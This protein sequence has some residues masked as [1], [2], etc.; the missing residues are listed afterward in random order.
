MTILF[1]VFIYG[2]TTTKTPVDYVN[3]YI[4]NISHLLVPTFPT[5]HLPNSM[6][7][8]YPEREN[9]TSNRISGLP[10]I[11][12]SHRGA[13]AF[14]L[15][16]FDGELENVGG[17]LN[18]GYDNEIIKPYYYQVDLDD[19]GIEVKYAPSHQAGMYVIN[20]DKQNINSCPH[21]IFNTRDGEIQVEGRTISGYQELQN[22]TR[23]FIFLE[24]DI[25]PVAVGTSVAGGIDTTKKLT[26]GKN[27]HFVLRFSESDKQI[28][29]RYGVSL[30]SEEQAKKNL[31]REINHYDL[32]R[33]IQVGRE[34]WNSTLGKINIEGDAEDEKTVFYTSLYRTYERMIC[35]SE[36]G[37]Y[38]S[39]YDNQIHDDK[40]EPFYVDD[41]IWDTYR[42]TH[43][44]R[45]I[46]E[47]EMEV[48]MINSF[49]RMAE[50]MDNFWMPTFPEV[51]GDS[52][53]MNSNHGV[54]TVIDA[55]KKGLRGFD[56]EKAYEACKNAIT[57][58]TL[59]PWSSKPAGEL[60]HFYKEKGYFPALAQGEKETIPEVHNWEKRQPIAVTLG[61]VYDEWCLAQIAKEL[62]EVD[63]YNYFIERSKNYRKVFNRETGFFH[64]KDQQGSFI[65]P[66]DYRFSGGLGARHAYDEN[67]GWVYRWD[68]PHNVAD[69][70][71]LL[72]GKEKFVQGLEDMFSEPLG[73]SRYEFY[74]NLPD[75]T[76]NVGQFSMG[77]EPSMHIP[78]LYNYAGE[79]WRTQK[80]VYNLLKQWFRNDL[81]GIPGDEDGGGLTSFVVFSQLGFYPVTPGLP[82]Y[83]IGTPRFEK[84]T[85]QIGNGKSFEI[86]CLN[87]SPEHKYIQ[88]ARLNG[89]VW[90]KSWFSH[91][92]LMKGGKLE[93]VMG[94]KP[95]KH[96]ASSE[97]AI[98]PSFEMN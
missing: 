76:G 27:A 80:R 10:L 22:N 85:M 38:F 55:Y 26:S 97:D 88:S 64:P 59:A 51:T 53:R 60:D 39:A 65:E 82:M 32:D 94:K 71:E 70:I 46:I 73:K 8:V 6:V 87:Y 91:D 69:L 84:V 68:V 48:N 13:S 86:V 34:L 66:F 24:T 18:Y 52:R 9:F 12:T 36:D 92:D 83:V 61:T 89:E 28:K 40:G 35:I 37:Q 43:P 3:P 95:N 49:I 5:I 29:V 2:N 44:L 67:N 74:A 25:A 58:K 1:P 50:Q 20:F 11:V 93:L 42:A 45:V 72:G 62:G 16:P 21:L 56:L 98:P 96:W 19:Y 75:H 63:D 30:I 77:N 81:M 17:V 31:R 78:Y 54:A 90:N 4:G 47:P 23:V 79:P 57:E 7:R 33:L 15:S 14:N 41:W